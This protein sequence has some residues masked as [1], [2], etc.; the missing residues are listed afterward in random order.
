[1]AREN[2]D[3]LASLAHETGGLF[4][5]NN[6]DL[7]KGIQQAFADGR[8]YYVLAY[9]PE[10]SLMDGTYRKIAVAVKNRKWRVSAKRG[11]WATGN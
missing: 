6:N 5:E 7:F 2:S 10:N 1:M 8:E 3:V 11:Y 9:V 4:F